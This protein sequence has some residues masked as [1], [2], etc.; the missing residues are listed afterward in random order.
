METGTERIAAYQPFVLLCRRS[1]PNSLSKDGSS[2]LYVDPLISKDDV[3]AESCM[4]ISEGEHTRSVVEDDLLLL[5]EPTTFSQLR[6]QSEINVVFQ[7]GVASAAAVAL[8]FLECSRAWAGPEIASVQDAAS[9]WGDLDD[10]KSGFVSAFLLIFFSEIGDKTFFIAAVLASRKSNIA[11]FTG[12]FGALVAMT[13]I[14]VFLGRT[15]HYIDGILPFSL[16]ENDLPLDDL[17]AVILLVYFGATTLLEAASMEGSKAQEEQQEAELAIAGLGGNGKGS[18]VTNTALATFGLVFVAEWGDKSFFSTVAL[19]AASS[20]VGVVLG[21]V[22]GHG[23]ATLLA[24]LG[25]SFLSNY[26][27]EKVTAYIGGSLFLIF[28]A[29]TLYEIL[30]V[31]S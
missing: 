29:F 27:S 21:A 28:A 2:L 6:I 31:R 26:I 17:A 3:Y 8:A 23:I 22:A 9:W 7:L 14:S 16:G 10:I 15:F 5:T 18:A 12:T 24:V 1:S 11:V 13:F 19:S 20:P 4:P 30:S 25:G